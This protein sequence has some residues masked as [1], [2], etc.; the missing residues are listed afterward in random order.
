LEEVV[1]ESGY[2]QNIV[3]DSNNIEKPESDNEATIAGETVGD[4][5]ENAHETETMK[6]HLLNLDD[7]KEQLLFW[8]G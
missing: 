3:Q 7:K 8:R 2:K 1:D 5:E 4:V 6:D